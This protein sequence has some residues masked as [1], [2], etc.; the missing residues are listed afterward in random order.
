[1]ECNKEEAIRAKEIAEKKMISKDFPGARKVVLKAQQLYNDLE[2]ISQ[3]LMVC[4]VHCA[5]EK[6][7]FGNEM[8]WYG[9]LQIGQNADEATIK[10]Q[11][12]KYALLLHP[13]KN[14][15]PGAEA[16][17]KLI[18]EAQRV[19]LDQ[20]KRSAYD[21]KW[22][23]TFRSSAQA[24]PASRHPQ[25]SS[26]HTHV[27]ARP[28]F[29]P[30]C[31]GSVPPQK[32]PQQQS[33]QAYSNGRPT[34]WTK[35]PFC[36][37]RYQY[38]T[39]ILHR[40]LR[41][42]TC[43][44]SFIA[45]NLGA[46]PQATNPSQPKVPEQKDV[47]S[48]SAQ[49]MEQGFREKLSTENPEVASSSKVP[50]ASHVG[51]KN[52]NGKRGRKQTVESSESC[53]TQSS[54]DS[55]EDVLIDE[56][57]DV[58]AGKDFRCFGENLRRSGRRK[59][60]VSYKENLSDDED[61]V[62]MPKRV[63][64]SGSSNAA[65]ENGDAL[66]GGA[67]K[68]N[69]QSGLPK[70]MEQTK[71]ARFQGSLANGKKET[72]VFGKETVEDSDPK[73][74]F[75]DCGDGGKKNFN[76][77]SES[78]LSPQSTQG[79]EIYSYPDPDFHDFDKDRKEE[80]FAAGQIW[81]AYDTLGAMPRFYVRI[82]KVF[83]PGFKLRMTWLEPDPD[84]EK[85]I[86]WVDEGLPVSC[87]KFRHGDMEN[88]ED[89]LMFSHLVYCNKGTG[90]DTYKIFPRKG[91]TWALFKNWDIKWNSDVGTNGKFE[92]EFVEILSE[93][94]EGVGIHVAYL[95]K[96]KGFV[97]LFCRM[98]KDGIDAFQ[99]P[100]GELFRFSHRVPSFKLTGDER[101]GVPKGSFELDPASLPAKL[102]EISVPVDSHSSPL[103]KV[104]ERMGSKKSAPLN[105]D[106]VKQTAINLENDS[107][108]N[109]AEDHTSCSAS[110]PGNIEYPDPE[111]YNFDDERSQEK[112][113]VGQIWSLYCDEDGLPK[114]YGQI[115][116]IE[117]NPTFELHVKWLIACPS[118]KMI[119]WHDKK[120]PIC[121]GRFKL[122]KGSSQVYANTSSFSHQL[123]AEDAGRKNEYKIFPR[124]GEVWAL[125]RNWTAEIKLSDLENWEYD[126]VEVMD[127]SDLW[128]K[129][130]I[131]ERVNGFNS[132]FKATL[133][134]RTYV[135]VEI[136]RVELLRF[137][138]QMPSFRLTDE[139]GGGL[140]GF[141]ELDPAALPVYYFS[142]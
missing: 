72:E 27:T 64:G 112:F 19:L 60:E 115:I 86:K 105:C 71:G 103:E 90:R 51:T 40:T 21:M 109:A 118:Q 50:H 23:V 84:D 87:G 54:S 104:K 56:S 81:A 88:T 34:F 134:G 75:K 68:I 52:V 10:K 42:Q 74:F 69:N 114:Y 117:S 47:Q 137:S 135:T 98:V 76:A 9:I 85:E 8:D 119:Q 111:F 30:N 67:P 94:A 92:Y 14:K 13:D 35:C 96:V 37:V 58:Q 124:K 97:S 120:M 15:F 113:Q 142:S 22:R 11:Y 102:E 136:P 28:N 141:W 116:K 126:V 138:H 45:Y 1:M 91:E 83:S 139:R 33:Q 106:G 53:D 7:I 2:N 46:A 130:I 4:E 24:A 17:F 6:M 127:E 20:S 82:R 99:I 26:S 3:M 80:C 57:G 12:R 129:V 61:L 110:L 73:K 121:C 38:Y 29:R 31:K 125:Y 36:T 89:R 131:L 101:K 62:S 93:Y 16:A 25:T 32:Q 55:E 43:N 132:V 79:P 78:N 65:E 5:A 18:G 44:K 107:A 49:K 70:V 122:K 66:K 100:P 39:D 59:Q 77:D 123:K 133:K 95:V 140:R 108:N 48:Q 63:K 128:I 41:C